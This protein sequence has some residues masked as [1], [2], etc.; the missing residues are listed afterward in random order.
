[1]RYVYITDAIQFIY[2]GILILAVV[3]FS[4]LNLRALKDIKNS[5]KEYKEI[6]EKNIKFTNKRV[7]GNCCK[8]TKLEPKVNGK[9]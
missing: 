4:I 5:F 1:M 8:G 6:L 3:L 9:S 2:I 7:K